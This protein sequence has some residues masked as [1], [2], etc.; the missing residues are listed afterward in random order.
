MPAF[1]PNGGSSSLGLNPV[2][3]YVAPAGNDGNG[4]TT[5]QS[6][7]KTGYAGYQKIVAAGGG[8]LNIASGTSWGGPVD[9]QG[10]WFRGDGV[11]AAG[12]SAIVPC[13]ITGFG[14]G[15]AS[16][17]PQ[18]GTA[19]L[20]AGD[21]RAAAFRNKP[22]VWFIRTEHTVIMN[23]IQ[24]KPI[25]AYN[26]GQDGNYAA[27]RTGWDYLRKEDGTTDGLTISS[28]TRAAGKTTHTVTLTTPVSINSA[29]RVSNVTTV[30]IF[31]P[32]LV[33]SPPW[34]GGSK[35]WLASTDVH[36]TSGAYDIVQSSAQND[37]DAV[38][39]FTISDPGTDTAVITTPGTVRSTYVRLFDNIEINSSSAQFPSTMYEV[40]STTITGANSGTIV[41]LDPY[42]TGYNG[43]TASAGPTTNIGTLL[44]Q[45]RG[46]NG[47]A[48]TTFNG[49]NSRRG[50]DASK[51]TRYAPMFDFGTALA[52]N[53]IMNG[54]YMEGYFPTVASGIPHDPLNYSSCY[55]EGEGGV[56]SS[57]LEAY[58]TR[59]IAATFWVG[60]GQTSGV[61]YIDGAV[62]DA[63]DPSGETPPAYLIFGTNGGFVRVNDII[64]S[65]AI[66]GFGTDLNSITGIP[67]VNVTG[68]SAPGLNAPFTSGLGAE[69]FGKMVIG[70]AGF[71]I[72]A[73]NTKI[74]GAG[75]G[76]L[77]LTGTGTKYEPR[78]A[79]DSTTIIGWVALLQAAV[80]P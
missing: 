15:S 53:Y 2:T 47:C 9:G 68:N 51:Y 13:I 10:A 46:Y 37:A 74:V 77:T 23:N 42:G 38:W 65:D 4:G 70:A 21:N 3:I 66:A 59:G 8:Y 72:D 61:C 79:A 26:D 71:G 30:T 44:V 7:M 73:A 45:G 63:N 39:T 55:A 43:V 31:R 1:P 14:P 75:S 5:W 57:S 24:V 76:Q 60:V 11:P 54:C 28:S 16:S 48:G 50:Q 34:K 25:P 6:A 29:Q 67:L 22:G 19:I 49:C 27:F 18:P 64:V 32:G 69:L 40:F 56:G 80:N 17:F 35:I 12:F 36:F 52:F 33:K 58:N 20:Y 78:Y 41:V 62:F